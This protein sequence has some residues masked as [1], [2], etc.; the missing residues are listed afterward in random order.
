MLPLIVLG[1]ADGLYVRLKTAL[2]G[3]GGNAGGVGAAL[4]LGALALFVVG[5]VV[6][7][8]SRGDA[9]DR[10][11][12]LQTVAT[13]LLVVGLLPL[14]DVVDL[15]LGG[16]LQV[17]VSAFYLVA[18]LALAVRRPAARAAAAV[19][20]ALPA[21]VATAVMAAVGAGWEPTDLVVSL[22]DRPL[23]EATRDAAA[24]LLLV[25][26]A[27]ALAAWTAAVLRR[28][29]VQAYYDGSEAAPPLA[30]E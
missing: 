23:S 19:L 21:V 6:G 27:W 17:P 7:W 5:A 10:P 14:F 28:D 30:V 4:S 16:R 8:R 11:R 29:G 26:P 20:A 18:S 15:W 9:D 24:Y 1:A 13:V 25:V 3:P 22:T 2:A 12:R